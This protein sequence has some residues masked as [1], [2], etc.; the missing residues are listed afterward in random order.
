MTIKPVL[1]LNIHEKLDSNYDVILNKNNMCYPRMTKIFH[2]KMH[3]ETVYDH[4]K[5]GIDKFLD[6][7]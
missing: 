7:N 3:Y 6:L 5:F 1:I 4:K 2:D